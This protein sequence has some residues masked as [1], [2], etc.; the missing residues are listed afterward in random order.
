MARPIGEGQAGKKGSADKLAVIVLG[1]Q[2]SG[3]SSVWCSLLDQ[4]RLALWD[5]KN[6]RWIDLTNKKQVG[7]FSQW[8]QA[9]VIYSSCTET[10]KKIQNR[11][12]TPLPDIVLCSAQ[13]HA[14][15]IP[16]FDFFHANGYELK[17]VW[18]DP[19]ATGAPYPAVP[20]FTDLVLNTYRGDIRKRPG[21]KGWKDPRSVANAELVREIVQGW[22]ARRV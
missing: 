10:G 5:K 1:L 16:T 22:L 7:N 21:G 15:E 6:I 20:D 17:V 18:L 14:Q 11:L 9:A 4:K 19:G 2:N 3:K 8:C 12:S 13:Y